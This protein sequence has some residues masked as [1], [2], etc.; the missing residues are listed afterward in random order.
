M[1]SRVQSSACGRGAKCQRAAAA[2]AREEEKPG[3]ETSL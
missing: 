2:A 3:A 1:T